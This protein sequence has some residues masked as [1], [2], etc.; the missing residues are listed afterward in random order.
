MQKTAH[1]AGGN[2]YK[3][4]EWSEKARKTGILVRVSSD[5]KI[6]E[7]IGRMD[8]PSEV[9]AE[10]RQN[11][12]MRTKV[13][14][15]LWEI[16][17]QPQVIKEYIF[18]DEVYPEY[19]KEFEQLMSKYGSKNLLYIGPNMKIDFSQVDI[20]DF[21]VID[22]DSEHQLFLTSE[23]IGMPLKEFLLWYK[24]LEDPKPSV[25]VEWS[26]ITR[27]RLHWVYSR[28]ISIFKYYLLNA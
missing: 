14:E 28:V 24:G 27:N 5:G 13:I 16:A 23:R 19:E 17:I 21:E 12:L 7:I 25:L 4:S 3:T 10:E 2:W 11:E 18:S 26:G 20:N 1:L 6:S 15:D 9:A 8:T 22:A